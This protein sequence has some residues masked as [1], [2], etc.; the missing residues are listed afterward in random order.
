[1]LH[2]RNCSVYRPFANMTS[3]VS[4]DKQGF[5][6]FESIP[7]SLFLE[8]INRNCICETNSLYHI[9]IE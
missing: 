8:I 5:R 6:E 9:I 2:R 4:P 3:V 7:R 1:M